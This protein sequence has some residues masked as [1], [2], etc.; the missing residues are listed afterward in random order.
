MSRRIVASLVVCLAGVAG[1][2]AQ[3]EGEFRSGPKVGTVLPKAFDAHVVNGKAKGRQ[4]CIVCDFG[5]NPSVLVFAR[6]SADGKN[7]SLDE[8]LKKLDELLEERDP[9]RPLH[10]AAIFLSPAARTAA[11]DPETADPSKLVEE[12]T[13]REALYARLTKRA[14]GLKNL[15]VAAY[16][17]E[18]PKEADG[19][20]AKTVGPKGYQLDPKADVTVLVYDRMRVKATFAFADGKLGDEDVEAITKKVRE[21]VGKKKS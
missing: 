11:I 13:A 14:E 15:I 12:A 16:P 21:V 19:A 1:L 4:H 6:E 3:D 10:G 5:L 17:L 8:L 7:G 2:L 20:D 18:G 9:D